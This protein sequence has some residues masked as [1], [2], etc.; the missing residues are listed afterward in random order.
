MYIYVR[1]S[2]HTYIFMYECACMYLIMYMRIR[3]CMYMYGCSQISKECMLI[4][5]II[6]SI[7]Y[8][9]SSKIRI[10]FIIE[11]N[12][13]VCERRHYSYSSIYNNYYYINVK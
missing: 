10:Y 5:F 12:F 7:V 2:S 6:K 8:Y 13:T 11:N 4:L 9:L 1:I 3:T